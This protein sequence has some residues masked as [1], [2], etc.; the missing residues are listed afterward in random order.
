MNYSVCIDALF[1]KMPLR[2]A[3]QAVK[4]CGF[5]AIEF[6]SFWD[7][8]IEELS[9][10]CK[11]FEIRVAAFCTDFR[12]NPGDRRNH[13]TY[14]EGLKQAADAAAKLGCSMLITQVGNSI[15]GISEEEHDAALLDVF[16]KAVPIL[17]ERELTLLVE[18]LNVK[19]DHPGYHMKETAHA[20]ALL[21]RVGSERIKILFD[22]YH[23]QIT[24]GDL[25]ATVAGHLQKIAHFHLAAV[26]GRTEPTDGE[27]NYPYLIR[28]IHKLGYD[29]FFGLEYMPKTD[30][31][32][33]LRKVREQFP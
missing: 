25:Y 13:E 2:E 22:L 16:Q 6:W 12:P 9:T 19:V 33:T 32:K 28:E 24:E 31:A 18:P 30:P 15:P 29:G 8:D 23:Q 10:L 11:E 17:K 21:D 7:K 1:P 3:L 5:S 4:D 20:V 26:P 14:L 27:V